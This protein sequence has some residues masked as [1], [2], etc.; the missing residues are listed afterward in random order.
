MGLISPFSQIGDK[1]NYQIVKIASLTAEGTF[2]AMDGE[3]G[4]RWEEE[5]WGSF[6]GGKSSPNQLHTQMLDL[7]PVDSHSMFPGSLTSKRL[8]IGSCLSLSWYQNIPFVLNIKWQFEERNDSF[9]FTNQSS[10]DLSG[11]VFRSFVAMRMLVLAL[12]RLSLLILA[13][14]LT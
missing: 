6:S 5:V 14:M 4:S 8:V 3:D 7:L 1:P 11:R 10:F 12:K 2:S 13:H 9:P